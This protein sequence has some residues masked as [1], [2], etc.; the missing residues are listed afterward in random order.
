MYERCRREQERMMIPTDDPPEIA[1]TSDHL[2]TSSIQ[3]F[4]QGE[5]LGDACS[6]GLMPKKSLGGPGGEAGV[7]EGRRGVFG[8]LEI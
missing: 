7:V 4:F 3:A 5:I 8:E 6:E 2:A 1:T